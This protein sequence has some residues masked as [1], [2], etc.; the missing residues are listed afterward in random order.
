CD[1]RQCTVFRFDGTLIHLVAQHHL[2]PEAL[3]EFQRAYPLPLDADTMAARVIRG[4]AIINSPDLLSDPEASELV[5]RMARAGGYRSLI[6]VPMLR[7]GAPI[8]VIGVTRSAADGGP[9]PFS[10]KET[11]LLET[12]ADQAVIAI[13]NV[14][15][16]Q[17]LEARNRELTE[18]LE[19]Q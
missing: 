13:E 14:R 3:H 19:Q 9:R 4:R 2:S 15:L 6:G 1:A 8:G 11:A 18:A 16:F 10:D 7:S 12:F 5:R 17:E